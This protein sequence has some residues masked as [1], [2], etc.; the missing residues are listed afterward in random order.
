M[1]RLY[2]AGGWFTKEQEEE[3]TRISSLLESKFSVFNPRKEGEVT[4][5]SSKDFM[6]KCL[7]GN[8]NGIE[9]A[10]VVV[11]IYDYKDTGTIWEAG[12]AYSS[13]KTIVYYAEKLNG[14]KFNLMLAKTGFFASNEKELMDTL[15][16][17]EETKGLYGYVPFKEV[18]DSYEGEVE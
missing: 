14:K 12:F 11:V 13:K 8:I 9:T 6:T 1:L 15:H 18:H 16:I 17:L 7:L 3:H 5:S 2:C 4:S 10:D